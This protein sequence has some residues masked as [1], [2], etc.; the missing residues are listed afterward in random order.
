[1]QER[2]AGDGSGAVVV[3][4]DDS[5]AASHALDWALDE[6]AL[7]GRH[8]KV[9][10]TWSPNAWSGMV[11]PGYSGPPIVTDL[12]PEARGFLDE[13]VAKALARR[14]HASTVTLEADLVE[15]E[16]GRVLVEA[17]GRA[18]LVVVGGRGYG[19]LKSGLLGSATNYVLHHAVCPVMV[20]P[21]TAA[22][23]DAVR[24][25]LVGVDGSEASRSALRWALAAAQRHRCPLV[26]VHACV[27]TLPP[28]RDALL[29]A[30][31]LS[32]VA[33]QARTGLE[34]VLAQTVPDTGGVD[35][36]TL[37]VHEN[38]P[39]GLLDAAGTDDLLVVGSRGRGGFAS[40]VLGSV[41]TQVTHHAH[42]PVVVVRQGQER[43]S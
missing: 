30:P 37:V 27:T 1:M 15:G 32:A 17:S 39:W 10:H 14:P 7:S 11:G 22:A 25:V 26:A 3:G 42:G 9:L 5:V 41:A 38:A 12:E 4:V 33:T 31:D 2:D 40:L 18:A 20:V 16:P 24:R 6:A 13:Q 19:Q 36:S 43:L 29:R 21:A 28:G 35:V 8:L 34:E 23:T